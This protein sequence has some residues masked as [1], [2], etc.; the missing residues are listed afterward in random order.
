MSP[1]AGRQNAHAWIS[2][3]NLILREKAPRRTS[4]DLRYLQSRP[5]RASLQAPHRR[6]RSY[7]ARAKLLLA[8]KKV[9]S[10]L[11]GARRPGHAATASLYPSKPVAP[12][13]LSIDGSGA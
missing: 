9:P 5:G 10:D 12:L 1:L 13:A 8:V 6:N 3:L 4:P 2:L 7:A 11:P